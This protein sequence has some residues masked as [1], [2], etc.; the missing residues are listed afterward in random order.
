MSGFAALRLQARR[1]VH[2]TFAGPATYQ[3]S[4][5]DEAVALRV[6]WHNKRATLG[7]IESQGYAQVVDS[8]DRLVFDQDELTTKDVTLRH[9]GVVTMD[10]GAVYSLDV[11]DPSNG[12]IS[13]SWTAVR[14]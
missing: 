7:D 12:P 3:D 5:M 9:R 11:Q 10:D 6:R 8:V 13:V 1:T 4:S 14:Q 2:D